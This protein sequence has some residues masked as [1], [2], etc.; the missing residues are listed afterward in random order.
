M[1]N[2]KT[3]NFF[4]IKLKFNKMKK[5]LVFPFLVCSFFCF[6]VYCQTDSIVRKII[7]MI[8]DGMGANQVFAAYTVNH[9]ILNLLKSQYIGFSLT[10]SANSYITDSGAGGTAI[11][12]GRKTNNDM[13][14]VDPDSTKLKTIIE[15]AEENG[16]ATGLIVTSSITD[17]TP[18]AFF[19]HVP[20]REE[21]EKIAA[22]FRGKGIDIFIGGGKQ[23]FEKRSDSQ[24]ISDS[25]RSDG[26]EIVY[27][28][29][30]I[31]PDNYANICCFLADG[32]MEPITK[33][34]SNLLANATEVALK[35]LSKNS[36]G[37]FI[38][39][40]GSQIDW[41]GHAN[42]SGFVVAEVSD[43]DKAVGRAFDFADNNPGTL[44]I[45]TA[46][47]ETGGL[48]IIDG[49]IDKGTIDAKFVST[50]HTGIMVPVYAYG[51]GAEKF[52]GI[53]QNTE[54]YN[55]MMELLKLE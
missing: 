25:L 19:A 7:L 1:Q 53:Y 38:M 41:A 44:V 30:D 24:N 49:D 22:D 26:Y 48:S 4:Y 27:D 36:T 16:Q 43:F 52:A 21:Y 13:I 29:K 18:A 35:K 40:E 39:I 2:I 31:D 45:V 47:H 33:R 50:D 34:E 3:K 17:A 23:Y 12:T 9:G 20:N 10:Q 14:A 54:I 8:G 11:S 15:S 28:I 51:T 42:H 5:F 6:Q 32:N 37:F 46:D 55:K